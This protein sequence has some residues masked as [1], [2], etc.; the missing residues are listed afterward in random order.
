MPAT[1][2]GHIISAL[3]R[4]R[5]PIS[6]LLIRKFW[7]FYCN[8]SE[9]LEFFRVFCAMYGPEVSLSAGYLSESSFRGGCFVAMTAALLLVPI[10][11]N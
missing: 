8:K 1:E 9:N 5:A 6:Q 3:Y 7:I 4:F 2:L 11:T 10:Y